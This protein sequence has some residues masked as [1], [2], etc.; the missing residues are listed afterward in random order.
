MNFLKYFFL[1]N[2]SLLR[3]IISQYFGC[4]PSN[5]SNKDLQRVAVISQS[6]LWSKTMIHTLR[7]VQIVCP[8]NPFRCHLKNKC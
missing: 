3:S 2:T 8:L 1:K 5:C 7:D 6:N 4:K